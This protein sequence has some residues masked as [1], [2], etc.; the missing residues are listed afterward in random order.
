MMISIYKWKILKPGGIKM[1]YPSKYVLVTDIDDW[2]P[3]STTSG[4]STQSSPNTA[5]PTSQQV[6]SSLTAA[7]SNSLA[8][9][10]ALGDL[11]SMLTTGTCTTTNPNG[12]SRNNPGR[13]G[14]PLMNPPLTVPESPSND[15][16]NQNS[17][18]SAAINNSASVLIPERVW[19]DC[20]MHAAP[21]VIASSQQSP[22]SA[23]GESGGISVKSEPKDPSSNVSSTSSMSVASSGAGGSGNSSENNVT[24]GSTALVDANANSV[25]EITDPT[26]KVPCCCIK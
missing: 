23:L 16:G 24:S 3:P 20:I 21:P 2:S 4:G 17:M 12:I 25:W 22:N 7:V 8:G 6:A 10:N 14:K 26:V 18:S 1:R 5:K 13:D 11:N 19:Q 15:L 9:T